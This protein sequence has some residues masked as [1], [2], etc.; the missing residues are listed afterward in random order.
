MSECFVVDDATN[1]RESGHKHS[2]IDRNRHE[3][4]LSTV[5]GTQFCIPP[6][7]SCDVAGDLKLVLMCLLIYVAY[8]QFLLDLVCKVPEMRT[9]VLA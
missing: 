4:S 2:R 6:A 3:T 9:Y 1:Q 5:D 8:E 7:Y